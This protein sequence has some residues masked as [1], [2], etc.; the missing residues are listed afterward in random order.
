LVDT[1]R[2]DSNFRSS[3]SALLISCGGTP[4]LTRAELVREI[5][6]TVFYDE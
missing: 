1:T 2:G 3:A 4:P 6:E 5:D